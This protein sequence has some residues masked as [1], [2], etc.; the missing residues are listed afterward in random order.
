MN[1]IRVLRHAVE[2]LP[3]LLQTADWRSLHVDYHPPIVDRLWAVF[4]INENGVVPNEGQYRIYLH[5]IHP[6]SAKE[7][8]FHPHP[9]P[10]AMV[11]CDVAKY[12]E[13]EHGYEMGLGFGDPA[14]PSPPIIGPIYLPHGSV[15]QMLRPDEWHYV[16]PINKSA[17][18]IMVTGPKF[19]NA[20][21]GE[22]KKLRELN[23][24]ERTSLEVYF[25]N[26]AV[27]SFALKHV[28]WA[29]VNG[30]D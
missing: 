29:D 4:G 12:W 16:A 1:M 5:N 18:T 9:W 20:P 14:G 7:S 8:L 3:N 24:D 15:Y 26:A 28:I 21:V 22:K 11:L 6:C 27:Q 17:M 10:S 23:D 19:D 13:P 2:A 25:R 30:N